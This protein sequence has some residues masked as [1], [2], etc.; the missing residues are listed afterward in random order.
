LLLNQISAQ[1]E[2][3]GLRDKKLKNKKTIT[4]SLITVAIIVLCVIPVLSIVI[5][6]FCGIETKIVWKN[7]Y[8]SNVI[9]E[10]NTKAIGEAIPFLLSILLVELSV[11]TLRKSSLSSWRFA[12]II[13]SLVMTGNMIYKVFYEAFYTIINLD[14]KRQINLFS[15]IQIAFPYN[16][17]ILIGIIFFFFIYANRVTRKIKEYIN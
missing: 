10:N 3:V 16:L 12:L 5:C 1:I 11:A 13:I 7:F 14:S 8:L 2:L 9:L 15:T 17:L 4:L 6:K